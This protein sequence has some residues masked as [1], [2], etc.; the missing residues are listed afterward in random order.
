MMMVLGA[1]LPGH[2]VPVH[3]HPH[4]RIGMV[5]AGKAVLRIAKLVLA[6]SRL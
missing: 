3:A 4:E 6:M 1:T 5:N 2:T